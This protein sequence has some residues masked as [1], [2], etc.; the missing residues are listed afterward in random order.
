MIFLLGG[1]FGLMFLSQEGVIQNNRAPEDGFA[2]EGVSVKYPT[3]KTFLQLEKDTSVTR[4]DIVKV[5]K[6]VQPIEEEPED[7]LEIVSE[8]PTKK[9]S[10]QRPD[11]SK[12]DTTQ[13]VRIRYA[14]SN[15]DFAAELQEKLSSRNCR[16][17]H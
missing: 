13:I 1:L 4:N 16:I 12:I 7:D 14:D 8:L 2:V 17:I 5:T 3:Y 6:T 15:P 11:F 9:D 10:L